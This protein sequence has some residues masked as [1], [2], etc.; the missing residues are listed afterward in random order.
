[1]QQEHRESLRPIEAEV[2]RVSHEDAMNVDPGTNTTNGSDP[3]DQ[4]W[5]WTADWQA[6]ENEASLEIQRG[7][8]S[9]PLRSVEEIRQHL[10][11]L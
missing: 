10:A 5:F 8:L 9:E 2:L 4:S 3:D 6:E 7:E 11:N 1:M